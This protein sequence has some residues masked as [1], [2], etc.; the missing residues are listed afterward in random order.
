M[1]SFSTVADRT[2]GLLEYPT[3]G[4]VAATPA[5]FLPS[6]MTAARPR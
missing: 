3:G 6:Q 1:A 4:M 2:V 5:M